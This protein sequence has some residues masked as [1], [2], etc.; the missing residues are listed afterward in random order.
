MIEQVLLE[1]GRIDVVVNNAFKPYI[2]NPDDRKNVLGVKMGRLPKPARW[3]ASFY[4]LYVSS[5]S[6]CYEK[7]KVR[8]V[9]SISLVI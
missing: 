7:N 1:M 6:S 3:S 2:F 8:E 9:L 4:S 5:S